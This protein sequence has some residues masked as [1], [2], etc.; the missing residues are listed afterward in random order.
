[1]S[2]VVHC[3]SL[4]EW[5]MSDCLYRRLVLVI[6]SLAPSRHKDIILRFLDLCIFP[7]S[8]SMVIR[9]LWPQ[10]RDSDDRHGQTAVCEQTQHN[11]TTA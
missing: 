9:S 5:N 1:M 2:D 6:D 11:K 10:V 7:Q 8:H 4:L 3:L